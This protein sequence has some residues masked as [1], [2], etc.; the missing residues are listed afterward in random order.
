MSSKSVFDIYDCII[1]KCAIMFVVR[2]PGACM[3]CPNCGHKTN[4]SDMTDEE[5]KDNSKKV[6]GKFVLE[7]DPRT[8]SEIELDNLKE[9][10]QKSSIDLINIRKTEKDLQI[11]Y[12]NMIAKNN[13]LNQ[14]KNK[15]IEQ[16]NKQKLERSL[17]QKKIEDSRISS[18]EV[19]QEPVSKKRKFESKND[20]S[21]LRE[22]LEFYK[23][24]FKSHRNSL[25]SQ[26]KIKTLNGE[27]IWIDH[28]R[29]DKNLI[30][31]LDRDS[32]VE[33]WLKPIKCER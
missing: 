7:K 6:I 28:I 8:N 20:I 26:V 1:C 13:D 24:V 14:K 30:E 17:Y 5:L 16:I 23:S 11:K 25:I 2:N 9:E 27:K 15:L 4:R 31:S 10:I 3:I 29:D 33:E 22:E 21:E 12:G 18:P 19:I 32:E